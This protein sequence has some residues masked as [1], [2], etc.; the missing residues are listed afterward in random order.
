MIDKIV[1]FVEKSGNNILVTK[2]FQRGLQD[3]KTRSAYIGDKLYYR[4]WTIREFR[5]TIKFSQSYNSGIPFK[6][7]R[8]KLD[9]EA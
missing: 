3:V 8:H 1:E 2:H 6:N 9:L 5:K 4:D 7:S